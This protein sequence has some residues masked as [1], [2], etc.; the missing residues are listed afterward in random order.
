MKKSILLGLFALCSQTGV[1]VAQM[2]FQASDSITVNNI[3][4]GVGA[5]GNIF[6]ELPPGGYP[7]PHCEFPRGSGKHLNF[8][9]ALWLS[10]YDGSGQ[11]HVAAQTYRIDG[12]DYWPGP[13]DGSAPL[14]Y[15]ESYKWGKVWKVSRSDIDVFRAAVAHDETNTP[16]SILTWPGKGNS[17]AKGNDGYALH[18]TKDMAPFVDVNGNGVYDPLAGDYPDIKGDQALWCVFNDNG[19]VHSQSRGKPLGVEVHTMVYGYKRNTLVDNV[20]FYEY[21]IINRSANTYTDTRAALWD[22]VELGYHLDDYVGYDASHRMGI[23]YNAMGNDGQNGS[24]PDI[25]YGVHVP[26]TGLSMVSLP[27]DGAGS[28]VPAGSFSLYNNDLSVM[29]IPDSD[30]EYSNY[31]RSK[32]RNGV[33]IRS[34]FK[35]PGMGCDTLGW[36][37]GVGTGP[38]CNFLFPGDPSDPNAWSECQCGDIQ[39]DRKFILS[40]GDFSLAAGGT[41]RVALAFMVSPEAGGCGTVSFADIK[42]LADTAWRVYHDPL[43]PNAVAEV[44][45]NGVRMYPNPAHDELHIEDMK[46]G[47]GDAAIAVY[48]ITGQ[49]VNVAASRRADGYT[50]EIG[51]LPAGMYHIEYVRGNMRQAANFVKN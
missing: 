45:K 38:L 23:T 22:D 43:L 11:L 19:P 49:K 48:N 8:T 14:S 40:S 33:H 28:Y 26:V 34:S 41:A 37:S 16:Q 24:F 29:G 25:S 21:D 6:D 36:G 27:G 47:G 3:S 30:I 5:F 31:M 51:A 9:A 32:I 2:V 20:L 10:G 50:L 44:G 42:S 15:A 17:F 4:A 12:S 35:G 13:I 18:I 39:G 1:A 7:L 46:N